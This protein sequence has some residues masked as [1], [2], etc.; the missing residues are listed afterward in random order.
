MERIRAITA[1]EHREMQQ[2]MRKQTRRRSNHLYFCLSTKRLIQHRVM[3][4]K[5]TRRSD[6]FIYVQLDH[7]TRMVKSVRE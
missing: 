2:Y 6:K 7:V 5:Q 1:V 4:P 3:E